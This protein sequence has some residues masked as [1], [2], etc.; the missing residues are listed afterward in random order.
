MWPFNQQ[1]SGQFLE[2]IVVSLAIVCITIILLTL[3][4]PYERLVPGR[5][6]VEIEQSVD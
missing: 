5:G 3:T 2:T 4:L 6:L 1:V